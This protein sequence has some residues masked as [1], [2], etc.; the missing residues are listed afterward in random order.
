VIKIILHGV[1]NTKY[2]ILGMRNPRNSWNLTDSSKPD[3]EEKCQ[4]GE[5]YLNLEKYLTLSG[6]EPDKFLKFIKVSFDLTA[7]IYWWKEFDICMCEERNSNSTTPKLTNKNLAP[8][9]F[10]F[11]NLKDNWNAE[12]LRFNNPI[13]AH[14]SCSW[15]SEKR[16]ESREA[17]FRELV[18][19]LPNA[20]LQ[21]RTII[22][23]YAE[24][25]NLY[26]QRCNHKLVEWREFCDWVKETLPYAENLICLEKSN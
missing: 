8:H 18:Q 21:K 3:Q 12:I 2:A 14:K 13:K 20:Y 4:L 15:D 19:D 5:K 23:N 24:L 25:R 9:G 22:T 6:P 16:N 7:P 17:I 10:S 1:Y 26:S 11:N